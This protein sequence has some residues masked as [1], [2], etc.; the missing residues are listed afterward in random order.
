MRTIE[1]RR[2]E[3]SHALVK[4]FRGENLSNLGEGPRVAERITQPTITV[5]PEHIRADLPPLDKIPLMNRS[6][7]AHFWH[8]GGKGICTVF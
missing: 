6:A 7:Q 8:A 1:F 3:S 5:S 4:F 2:R